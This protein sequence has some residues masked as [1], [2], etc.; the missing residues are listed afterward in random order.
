MRKLSERGFSA[1]AAGL[2][3]LVA[4]CGSRPEGPAPVI[5]GEAAATAGPVQVKVQPGQTLSGIAHAYHVPMQLVAAANH[6]AP[7]YRIEAGRTL[8][9]PQSDQSPA[10]LASPLAAVPPTSEQIAATKPPEAVPLER[11]ALPPSGNP[12]ATAA[13]PTQAAPAASAPIAE[14]P[15]PEVKSAATAPTRT[16]AAE[17]PAATATPSAPASDGGTFLWPVRGHIVA[18]YGTGRDGTHN[19]GINIAA[20]RGAAIEAT[21]GGVVAYAGNELRGY[22]NL[23]LVKHPNGW[24]SAYAHCDAILVKRGDKVSRGQTIARV[25]STGSVAEPQLHFE[26]RRGNHSVDPRDFLAP[27]PTAGSERGSP[28][29]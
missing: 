17:P 11:T 4:A 15:H 22:G 7:P 27:L 10:P 25:G 23:I 26:L 24:I 19:D 1:A 20:P 12:P 8:I 21:D 28:P 14:P 3:L 29:G 6:L 2:A 9:I 5:S 18:G 16:A 13:A